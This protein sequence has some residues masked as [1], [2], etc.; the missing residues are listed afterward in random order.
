MWHQVVQPPAELKE[1]PSVLL[2]AR[3]DDPEDSWVVPDEELGGYTATVHLIKQGHRRIGYIHEP[4]AF[5]AQ[6]LRLAGYRRALTEHGISFDPRLLAVGAND[7]FG[8]HDAAVQL[9]ALPE[10]PT[11]IQCY[12]DR[13]AMGVYRAIRRAG[14]TISDDI[15]VIGFDDQDQLAP[16]LDPPLT[17]MRLPHE[18]MGRWAV[19]HLIGVLSGETEGPRQQRLECPL[20]VR[21]SVAPPRDG[22]AFPLRS[23]RGT[24]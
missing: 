19:S 7:P 17:T 21:D 2:D 4:N 1:I 23:E 22:V 14:L 3:S 24:S 10:P 20:V 16:W 6:E 9:L 15:S 18:A 5:P 11:A 8:G 13:M 12:T